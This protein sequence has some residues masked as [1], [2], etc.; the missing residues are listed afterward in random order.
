MMKKIKNYLDTH[1]KQAE[2]LRYLI[3]G[4]LTTLLSMVIHYGL[5]FLLAEKE[6]FAGGNLIA[7]VADTINRATPGQMSVASAVSWVISV[8]FAFWINRVMVFQVEKASAGKVIME[9]LQFAGSRIVSF[10]VFEQ[11]MMLGL[12]AIGVSNIVNRIIV[13]I[14][15]MVFNYVAS[16]FWI[17]KSKADEKAQPEQ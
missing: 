8:L 11:G 15:V 5:C 16:K 2:L 14:F 9:L 17:F 10:L 3:A 7:W 6:A 12:K 4:G 13:L 1:P